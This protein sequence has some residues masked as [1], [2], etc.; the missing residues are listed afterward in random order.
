[1]QV[2]V[3]H[4]VP[5]KLDPEKITPSHIIIKMS[6]IKDTERILKV[7]REKKRVTYKGVP[8]SL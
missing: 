6:K 7:A 8:I 5:N 3:I 4:R 2:K 1:M